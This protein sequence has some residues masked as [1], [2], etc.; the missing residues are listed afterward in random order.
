MNT[1]CR[2]ISEKSTVSI[3]NRLK[4]K[5]P[6]VFSSTLGRCLK[7]K[8]KLDLKP[9]QIPVFRPKRPV[10]YSMYR[11][12]D[13]ELDRLERLNIISPIDYSEWAAPI[14]VVRKAN[15]AIRICGDYSTGLNKALQPHQYPL[16]LPQ[17]IFVK[18]ANCK[19]FSI[20]DMSDSYLQLEVDE[21]SS[22]LLSIN[23]H[24]GIYK[25]NRLAPGVKTAPGAFQQLVDTMLAGL[26]QTC[27]YIDD[28]VV[29]GTTQEEHW[30]NLNALFQRLQE[31]G[32]TV[33]LEKCSFGCKQI[34]YLG[35]LLDQH[36]IR[37]DPAK[38]EAIKQMPAPTDVSGVRSFLGA[39]NYYGKFVSNMRSLRYPLDELL[40]TSTCFKWTSECDRAFNTFK[41]I[42]SSD[43]LLTHYN[44]SL[45]IIVSADASSIGLGAT[46]SHRFPDGS[47]K[48][49]QHASRALAPAERNYSQIDREGL[50][51]I[52]AITKF[53]RMLFGRKF[54]LQTD[55]S[56]LLRIFGST[57]GIPVYTAS[58]LQRWALT[59]L[60]YE[61]EIEYVATDKFGHADILSRLINHHVKPDEDYVIA[62]MTLENDVRSVVSE[63]F[64]VLPLSFR[65]VRDRTHR[66][67]VLSKV[68]RFIQEGWPKALPANLDR[69]LQRYLNQRDS[70]TTV[71]GCILYN[72]RLVIP[73][74]LR[75]QCL[76]Q[77]HLGHPGI[78]R[79][80]AV[81]RSY[82]FWPSLDVE[83]AEY[84]RTCVHCAAAAK[85]P[86][87]IP[88]VP[89]PKSS[90]PWQRVH[91]D[92]AG[93]IDGEYFLLVVDSY[94]KWP[95]IV[96][97]RRITST[98]TINILR[99]LFARLG[100]PEKLVSDNGTQFTSI[101]FKQF[102]A[103][104]GIDHVTTAPFHPQSNGQVERFVDTFKRAINKIQEGRGSINAALDTFLLTY[105]S[106]PNQ[107]APNGLSPSEVMFGRR[108][109]T[110]LELLRPPP[111]CT[112][113][114]L[115]HQ[116]V[117]SRSLN[118]GNAVFVKVYAKNTW[119]WIPGTVIEKVGRVM[120]NVV[121]EGHRL[122]RCHINQLRNR[123]HS[124]NASGTSLQTT[125]RQLP[126]S[127]LLDAWELPTTTTTT[128]TPRSEVTPK[129]AL[130][131]DTVRTPSLSPSFPETSD[132]QQL[133]PDM[134]STATTTSTS[135]TVTAVT[136]SVHQP[137]R[138]SRVRRPP[139]R[140]TPY[141]RY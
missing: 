87:H 20:I 63:S 61:F 12:V 133:L 104:N 92:Y 137:W 110:C 1:F 69:E 122:V 44:P 93:P 106:T 135:E 96:Q 40:K 111:N 53:H 37:P 140:Y 130:T 45:E 65:T 88:P 79:M 58:R 97:T 134:S 114:S 48:V 54:L 82:V 35:H 38:I 100:M 27:G 56:P 11:S 23:T 105:R 17:D 126:L 28:I 75:K 7:T 39:I 25:V 30:N 139:K 101:E 52:F 62:A 55:H 71:Q 42:L 60:M 90:S 51:I 124:A 50:A 98:A 117:A 91:V 14:V 72:D 74:L 15:G 43:L 119:K 22:L 128:S 127:I 10:A 123:R 76:N 34:K 18:L 85:S 5:Y 4:A 49:V 26:K 24:R 138:S 41:Q 121:G 68:Y 80:K 113:E 16:P 141:Q 3:V 125:T 99:G 102:C 109:R 66:D 47:V 32:F 36:G 129:A 8:V 73:S 70:L 31:F 81:A 108:L 83:I 94:S 6:S 136:P 64:D 57:K 112:Q 118:K 86:A 120:Y 46:I 2:Q 78:G 33:R 19:F 103:E 84:V 77:I 67:P 21:A 95:E 9:N 89:W 59:L 131:S 107:S 132:S 13:E 115:Q 116:Q 29:G